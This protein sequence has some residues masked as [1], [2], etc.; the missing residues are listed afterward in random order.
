MRQHTQPANPREP[1]A[2][3]SAWIAP[4]RR[5]PGQSPSSLPLSCPA[6]D[7]A[8][9][10]QRPRRLNPELIAANTQ[11]QQTRWKPLQ[12][13]D[14][15]EV[16]GLAGNGYH[17]P[18]VFQALHRPHQFRPT[19]RH[20]RVELDD[21]AIR[22]C[23]AAPDFRVQRIE[24]VAS[25]SVRYGLRG[26]Q[27]A[28]RWLARVHK[29]RSVPTIRPASCPRLLEAPA[30]PARVRSRHA[31]PRAIGPGTRLASTGRHAGSDP[32]PAARWTQASPPGLLARESLQPASLAKSATTARHRRWQPPHRR[33]RHPH[34]PRGLGSAAQQD[35]LTCGP[36]PRVASSSTTSR[37]SMAS[38]WGRVGGM[39]RSQGASAPP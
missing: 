27:S 10:P 17:D 5:H 4:T 20:V 8:S 38:Y 22:A 1:V 7:E 16:P 34:P 35:P 37:T 11:A 13:S 2:P 30:V 9:T 23:L 12:L 18:V 31:M 19:Q 26:L 33:Q 39:D 29:R 28:R 24:P 36:A 25:Q 21:Q 32:S 14:P 15:G 3:A 6:L